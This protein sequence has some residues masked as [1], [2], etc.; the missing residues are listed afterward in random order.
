MKKRVSVILLFFSLSLG[1][2]NINITQ[3]DSS[4][5][6]SSQEIGLYIQVT[7]NRGTPVSGVKKESFSVYESS[8]DQDFANQSEIIELQEGINSLTG[9]NF[10]LLVD[11]SGSMYRTLQ[12][13]DTDNKSEMRITIAK[14]AISDF[15]NQSAD[16]RDTIA[17]ASFNS[18]YS[19]HS[20]DIRREGLN[21]LDQINK[22]SEDN[23]K[24]ELYRSVSESLAAFSRLQGR[25]VIIV[26]SDGAN[27]PREE[28]VLYDF[29]ETIIECQK[30]GI[31]VFAINFAGKADENLVKIAA[32]TGGNI[33]EASLRD[34]LF[35]VY[36]GIK[37]QI[38]KEYYL[39]YR[40][41][42]E[43]GDR[44]FVK[45]QYKEK[46]SVRVYFSSNVFGAPDALIPVFLLFLIPL[47]T[48]GIMVL[49]W[50]KKFEIPNSEAN[51]EVLQAAPG[52]KVSNNTVMLG[53]GETVIGGSGSADLTI[54][55]E[56][57]SEENYATIVY[58][59][60]SEHF[61]V[62]SSKTVLVNNQQTTERF[63]EAGDVLTIE[64]TTIVFDDEK[65]NTN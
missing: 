32:E 54:V 4:S 17:L 15:V 39:V 6:L 7:D 41:S 2:E 23:N 31:S 1:A 58:D 47:L 22:P 46:N 55:S 38:L 10:L 9:V 21:I 60:N 48:K 34:E 14:E 44:R 65:M 30:E 27:V 52:V 33:F 45:A 42:M 49:L 51:I 61:K 28:G 62:V 35:Q 64:G 36:D 18:Y 24:T 11:N 25:K 20:E 37:N 19:F 8:S 56:E 3:V 43:P 40:A 57:P 59:E 13:Q 16:I 63:L 26:L 29:K 50:Y 53:Q 12:G 5:L